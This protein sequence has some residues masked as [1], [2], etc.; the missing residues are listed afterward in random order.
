VATTFFEVN[1]TT[2]LPPR[3]R[4]RILPDGT[5]IELEEGGNGNIVLN[6]NGTNGGVTNG[7]GGTTLGV[8]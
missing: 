4:V 2:G 7:T 5:R 1:Q 3:K 6:G 8:T